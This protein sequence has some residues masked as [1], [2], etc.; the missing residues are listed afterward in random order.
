[1]RDFLISSKRLGLGAALGV[2][3]GLFVFGQAAEAANG[4]DVARDGL[5]PA[6]QTE[7]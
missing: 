5:D 1:M 6:G 2:V 3:F 7:V 4:L